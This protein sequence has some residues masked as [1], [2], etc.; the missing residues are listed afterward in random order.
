MKQYELAGKFTNG[1]G[2]S[3]HG[4]LHVK[5]PM[6]FRGD[7]EVI[8]LADGILH[9]HGEP[10]SPDLTIIFPSGENK[11]GSRIFIIEGGHFGDGQQIKC[12]ETLNIIGLTDFG[13][14]S[15]SI[16][17]P[18][19]QGVARPPEKYAAVDYAKALQCLAT[20]GT[21]YLCIV[22]SI[23]MN[24]LEIDGKHAGD[25]EFYIYDDISSGGSR[26]IVYDHIGGTPRKNT[27]L[28][29]PFTDGILFQVDDIG[30]IEHVEQVLFD[31][32]SKPD[33]TPS[34][35]L[36]G[37]MLGRLAK[38]YYREPIE[39][40]NMLYARGYLMSIINLPSFTSTT[41][42]TKI[43][44]LAAKY[45]T[46]SP[47]LEPDM[48]WLDVLTEIR[49]NMP[50]HLDID[51]ITENINSLLDSNIGF[52]I[53]AELHIIGLTFLLEELFGPNTAAVKKIAS[54]RFF[55]DTVEALRSIKTLPAQ[56]QD[57][58]R[59][60]DSSCEGVER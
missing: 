18:V 52:W 8:E 44:E 11:F 28:R 22:E 31:L 4:T 36:C 58:S 17:F 7:A 12:E 39:D 48:K 42:E 34:E 53:Q 59:M 13:L 41:Y 1:A 16:K 14:Q 33:P 35:K 2:D 3:A 6:F 25:A 9:F 60:Q 55:T 57:V 45:P 49:H 43:A 15:D 10:N 51:W 27:M 50:A 37:I 54:S 20:L 38:P 40:V 29:P 5:S 21:D 32:Y 19:R 26:K 24:N 30:G 56:S 47:L 23:S 46:L